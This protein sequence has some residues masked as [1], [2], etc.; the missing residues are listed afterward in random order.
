MKLRTNHRARPLSPGPRTGSNLRRR[1]LASLLAISLAPNAARA[2]DS[3]GVRVPEGFK[4]SLYADNELA[5][6]IFSMTIDSLGRVVVSG[7]GYVRILIDKDGDGRADSFEQLADGPASG[8]QGMVFHGRDLICT[9]DQGLLR[10]RDANGDDRADGPPELFLKVRAGGEHDAHAIRRGPDGWWYLISGNTAQIDESYVALASSP[11]RHPR[12]GTVMRF[13]PDLTAG[14]VFAHGY[15]N[16]YDFDFNADGDLLTFD[17]DGEREISLPAYQPTRVFHA[18]PGS[19]AGWLSDHWKRPGDF[20]D[21]PPVLAEFGRGSPTGVVCYQH[22]QF[23][24]PYRGALFVLDWTFGRIFALP[25]ARQGSA[26]GTTEPIAFL[27]TVGEHGFAPTDAE[28]GPDGALYVSVGGRG[29][30]GGVYRIESTARTAAPLPVDRVL[31]CVDSPQPLAAW[32]R[33]KWEPTADL[34]GAGAFQK[35]AADERET[36]ARRVRAIE[37]LTERF[38]GL[39]PQMAGR[40]AVSPQPAIRA[41]LAWSLGRTRPDDPSVP[42]LQTLLRDRD[43]FVQRAALEAALCSDNATLDELAVAVGQ[44]LAS[45]DRYVRMAAVRVMARMSRNGYA[46][47]STAALERGAATG[48][49]VAMAYSQRHPGY[50]KY[51]VDIAR[52]ILESN[53]TAALKLEAARLMQIG[54]GDVGAR[55]EELPEA[56]EGYTSRVDLSPSV[57]ELAVATRAV[58]G[59]FPSGDLLLDQEL[60]RVIAMLQPNDH[61]LL[62]KVVK[63]INAESNPVEDIHWLLVAARINAPRDAESRTALATALLQL[64]AKI[65][66]RSLLIDTHWDEQVAEIYTALVERDEELPVAIL[67]NPTFGRPAHIQYVAALPLDH[68][69]E[70][71]AAFVKKINSDVDYAW[72]GDVVF[73]LSR[74]EDAEVQKLVRSKFEDQ[75]LRG[76]VL[77]SI[78]DQGVESDRPYFVAALENTAEEIL[79]VSLDCLAALPPNQEADEQIALVKVLRRL[80]DGRQERKLRSKIM[81]RLAANLG[82]EFEASE[83]G[84]GPKPAQQWASYVEEKFPAQF[85]LHSGQSAEGASLHETLGQVEWPNGDPGRGRKLFES[86]QCI[87]CHSGR[88]AVG[89]DLSGVANRFSHEDLFT[90]IVNP[91]RDVSPRYQT[92]AISTVDGRSFTGLIIYESVDYLV[93]RNASN[94]TS[95]IEKK[96]IEEQQTLSKSLMPEGLLKDLGPAD[97]ADLYAFLRAM[98]TVQTAESGSDATR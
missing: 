11:V 12:H 73:L 80:G 91:S 19:H 42:L 67:K 47:A 82:V 5:S 94:Q 24:A 10:F 78:A 21:M 2:D 93:L 32:S 62:T 69:H 39:D 40:L 37:I 29:T 46:K 30:R 16:A 76:A 56:F 48:I 27:T 90:A 26:P 6:D 18:A 77:L 61:E 86:R 4:V 98:G 54:L 51:P 95:R 59:V 87:Q 84:Q 65:A 13:K 28:V 83:D 45:P 50:Q 96:N 53:A 81:G 60:G 70:A 15:R 41:R 66:A 75:S 92:T 57:E 43:A 74:S 71:I 34:V 38:K 9:G 64:E 25:A 22:T 52:R 49:G 68:L 36:V 55:G 33:A 31:A 7:P 88:G 58:S 72:N 17:S 23:P 79:D 35:L 14:E 44:T 8:A 20:F 89:P 1:I 63:R 85:A 3:L 97:Y